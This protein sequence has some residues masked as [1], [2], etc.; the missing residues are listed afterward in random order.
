MTTDV[1]TN[2]SNNIVSCEFL[3]IRWTCDSHAWLNVLYC[4]LFSSGVSIRVRI[5]FVVWLVSGYAHVFVLLL[6]AIVTLPVVVMTYKL[7][8]SARA[9][10]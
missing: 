7:R 10:T 9:M 4:V 8:C 2:R 3:W 1:G 5:R 6:V